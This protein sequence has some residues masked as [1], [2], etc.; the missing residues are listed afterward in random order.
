MSLLNE[1]GMK[2]GKTAVK[3]K[4]SGEQLHSSRDQSE[5]G[6]EE[7]E[8]ERR[9]VDVSLEAIRDVRMRTEARGEG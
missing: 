1:E 7:Q 5:G 9:G 4:R 6:M 2:Y 3:M 8:G